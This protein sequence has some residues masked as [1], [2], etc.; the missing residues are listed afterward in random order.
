MDIVEDVTNTRTVSLSVETFPW[1]EHVTPDE[2]HNILQLGHYVFTTAHNVKV[3]ISTEQENMVEKQ[4]QSMATQLE[5]MSD[6]FSE[7]RTELNN[8]KKEIVNTNSLMQKKMCT[9]ALKGSFGE[10]SLHHYLVSHFPDDSFEMKTGAA[11]SGDIH[12]FPSDYSLGNIMIEVKTYKSVVPTSEVQ[13]FY[14]DLDRTNFSLGLFVSLTSAISRKRRFEIV[15]RNN[16]FIVFI[17]NALRNPMN[18]IC[19]VLLLQQLHKHVERMGSKKEENMT[20]HTVHD[21]NDRITN[22]IHVFETF[23]NHLANSHFDMKK[24]INAIDSI[25]MDLRRSICREKEH[26]QLI[27]NQIKQSFEMEIRKK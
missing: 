9:S 26:A 7:L 19:G 23:L 2:L 27:L 11:H 12:M 15:Y 8:T 21:L 17:P 18:T 14:N 10:Q 6:H 1:L 24:K 16:C 13:K 5:F 3:G 20:L 25:T 4:V 22:V